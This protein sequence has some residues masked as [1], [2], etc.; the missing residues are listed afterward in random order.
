MGIR[1]A[2]GEGSRTQGFML[3][4]GFGPMGAAG[5]GAAGSSVATFHWQQDF[6]APLILGQGE[7]FKID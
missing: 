7:D 3:A 4:K 1:A 6:A 2:I 5:I